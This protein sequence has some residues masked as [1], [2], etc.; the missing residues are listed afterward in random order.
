MNNLP[1]KSYAAKS[2][3]VNF[4]SSEIKA[5]IGI[6]NIANPYFLQHVL[7]IH[8][9]IFATGVR[10]CA[11]RLVEFYIVVIAATVKRIACLRGEVEV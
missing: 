8:W 3:L 1:V 10:E 7:Q 5:W 11:S 2:F 4:Y 6:L 9:S